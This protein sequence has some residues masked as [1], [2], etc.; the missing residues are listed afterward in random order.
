MNPQAN[1]SMPRCVQTVDIDTEL[2]R[3]NEVVRKL[4]STHFADE[5]G[6]S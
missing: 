4:T 6:Q 2:S 1:R 5:P 3:L